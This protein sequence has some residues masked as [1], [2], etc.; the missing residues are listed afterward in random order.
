[1]QVRSLL[2]VFAHPDDE[3]FGSGGTLARYAAEGV[4]IMLVCATR[5]EVG[6]ISDPAL[7]TPET[8]GNVRE[9]ELRNAA[10]V[11]GLT[12][13]RFLGYRDSGMAGTDNNQHPDAF[14]NTAAEPVVAQLVRLIRLLQPQ[15]VLTF[16][17]HGGYGHPD[18]IAIHQHTVAA[19]HAAGDAQRYP[20]QGSP[21]QVARLFYP[22]F[23]RGMLYKMRDLLVAANVDTSQFDRLAESDIGWPDDQVHAVLDVKSVVDVKW[24]ALHA[25][26]TQFGP[27]NPFR[28]LPEELAKQLMSREHFALAWPEPEPGLQLDDLFAGVEIQ[29]RT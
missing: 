5:G 13:V 23:T 4:H 1:M 21:W 16:D 28:Q 22:V 20:G 17:P 6:E 9:A 15:V 29:P 14:V 18:H 2:A 11:L 12:D 8:L 25:H 10:Q 19:V 26:R 24:S 27:N 3:A 7:A